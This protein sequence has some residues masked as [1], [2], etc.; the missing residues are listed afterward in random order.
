MPVELSFIYPL[1]TAYPVRGGRA[2]GAYPSIFGRKRGTPWT[3]C[4]FIAG[5][6][7]KDKQPSTL[8]FTPMGNLESPIN[9]PQ[10][11]IF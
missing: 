4:H 10:V 3:S 9:L 2:A 5:L 6:T 7:Y 8:T 1:S 11:C